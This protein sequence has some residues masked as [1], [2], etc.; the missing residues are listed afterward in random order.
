MIKKIYIISILVILLATTSI[1]GCIGDP[2]AD[3]TGPDYIPDNYSNTNNNTTDAGKIMFYQ[4]PAPLNLFI[5]AVVKDP[6]QH[7][8]KEVTNQFGSNESEYAKDYNDTLELNGHQ[9]N[10]K[11]QTVNFFG[12]SIST[13]QAVW[14]CDKTM[15]TY[16]TMGIVPTSDLEDMKNMTESIK[17]HPWYLF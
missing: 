17:C 9:V 4:G 16:A 5:V 10:M 3:F 15:L 1:S 13:F 6:T 8:F 11:I 14:Y 12:T 2:I 7:F